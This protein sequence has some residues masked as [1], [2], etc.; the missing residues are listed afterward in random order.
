MDTI[1][2]FGKC[3]ATFSNFNACKFSCNC[4]NVISMLAICSKK[5]AFKPVTTRVLTAAATKRAPRSIP[6]QPSAKLKHQTAPF[7]RG[8]LIANHMKQGYAYVT[9][10]R[11]I[12]PSKADRL[13]KNGKVT[14]IK[15]SSLQR[16]Y[17]S[18]FS[19]ILGIFDS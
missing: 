19:P 9:G 17:G 6:K 15:K 14:A 2:T 1:C 3:A 18:L 12:P 13:G 10:T 11:V 5:L 16:I 7:A 8:F 4:M